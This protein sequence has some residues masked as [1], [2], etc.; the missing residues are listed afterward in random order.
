LSGGG[1]LG[2]DL[3]GADVGSEV[4]EAQTVENVQALSVLNSEGSSEAVA[5]SCSV[6][7]LELASF[8][9]VSRSEDD[10]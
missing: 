7:N 4:G 5:S 6:D 3:S 9:T 1:V 10:I 8:I 2:S